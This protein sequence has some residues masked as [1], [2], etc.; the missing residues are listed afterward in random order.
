MERPAT[1]GIQLGRVRAASVSGNTISG[2][3]ERGTGI[4]ADSPQACSLQGNTVLFRGANIHGRGIA[5]TAGEDLAIGGNVVAG[6][7]F[8][9]H[10]DA[11]TRDSV[12]VGNAL[13]RCGQPLTGVSAA[14]GHVL[15]TE[16][17]DP[18]NRL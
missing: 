17:G 10:Q 4:R 12:I 6:A 3:A 5:I 18:Y 13:R 16:A 15:A 7:A 14:D 8:G 2:L 11:A 9:V 1:S